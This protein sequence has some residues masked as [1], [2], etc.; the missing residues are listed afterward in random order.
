MPDFS[1]QEP[2]QTAARSADITFVTRWVSAGHSLGPDGVRRR[3]MVGPGG[4][5]LIGT[6]QHIGRV[7]LTCL[8][9]L[10]WAGEPIRDVAQIREHGWLLAEQ[11]ATGE[12]CYVP[13]TPILIATSFTRI[14]P[15][16]PPIGLRVTPRWRLAAVLSGL[17]TVLTVANQA[18]V[19][20][21]LRGG[22]Q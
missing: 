21:R 1:S 11:R 12:P 8:G 20:A 19:C 16:E 5:A 22:S 14:R 4:I 13:V 9:L 6:I 17:P 7:R 18:L 2:A 10:S 15:G 3:V